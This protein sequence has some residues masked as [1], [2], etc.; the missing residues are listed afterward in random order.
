M[1]SVGARRLGTIRGS[2]RVLAVLLT[3]VGAAVA[4]LSGCSMGRAAWYETY[5][6]D[7]GNWERIDPVHGRVGSAFSDAGIRRTIS[8]PAPAE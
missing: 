2:R 6:A 8:D 3:L 1:S 7:G 5:T 4:G